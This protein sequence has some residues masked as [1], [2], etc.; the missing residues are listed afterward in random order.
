MKHEPAAWRRGV[1]VL[2]NRAEMNL[3]FAELVDELNETGK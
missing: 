1:D 3:S 2:H